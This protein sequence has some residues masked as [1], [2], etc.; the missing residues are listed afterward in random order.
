[1]GNGSGTAL[2]FLADAAKLSDEFA[3]FGDFEVGFGDFGHG[4]FQL[5]GDEG[6]TVGAEKALLV[7]VLL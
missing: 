5:L 7:G 6:T 2:K 3:G 4:G 1:M